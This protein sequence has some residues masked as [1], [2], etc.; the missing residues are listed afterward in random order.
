MWTPPQT[1]QCGHCGVVF[2]ETP[3]TAA[4]RIV[5]FGCENPETSPGSRY[6]VGRIAIHYHRCPI[7]R[8]FTISGESFDNTEMP[9]FAFSYPPV[10]GANVPSCIP[11]PIRDDYLEACSIVTLSPKASATLSRRCLQGMIRDFWGIPEKNLAKAISALEGKVPP[12][13][14]RVIDGIRHLGNIGAHMEADI[15]TIVEID[16]DEAEKLL[17]LIALLFHDWYVQREERAALYRDIIE[18]D[19]EKQK[20]RKG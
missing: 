6:I 11:D 17:K 12:D 7:C 10:T 1:F 14:W 3:Q 13:Q 15:N 2:E 5:E 16:A 20:K 18:I 4:I 9:N 8:K 19:Q